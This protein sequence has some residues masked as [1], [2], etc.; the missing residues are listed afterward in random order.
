MNVAIFQSFSVNSLLINVNTTFFLNLGFY[1]LFQSWCFSIWNSNHKSLF[2]INAIPY[3][4][5]FLFSAFTMFS[6]E[7]ESL[8]NVYRM[9]RT[10]DVLCKSK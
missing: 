7:Y 3:N 5:N 9:V 10:I 1:N 2:S 8:G 4:P 6:F